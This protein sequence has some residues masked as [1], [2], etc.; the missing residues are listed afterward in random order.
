M[1]CPYIPIAKDKT[2]VYKCYD[3]LWTPLYIGASNDVRARMANHLRKP[4]IK[5]LRFMVLRT[6]DNREF[7][8]RAEQQSI[9]E[10]RPLYNEG[11]ITKAKKMADH[12]SFFWPDPHLSP[13]A[14]IHWAT[15][16]RAKAKYRRDCFMLANGA[17]VTAAWCGPI[18][19]SLEFRPP[20][21][22]KYDLDGLL[23]RM[24]SGLDGLADALGLDDHRFQLHISIGAVVKGG[25]VNVTIG[26]GE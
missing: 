20:S 11:K 13:N 25:A 17:N 7:A 10:E 26:K 14:R 5:H 1:T 8:F 19:V 18:L 21:R 24:K 15:H 2:T 9:L 4:W 12:V 3:M 6:F 22:R 23:S 16:A